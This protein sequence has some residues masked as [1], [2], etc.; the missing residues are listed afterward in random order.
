MRFFKA[1]IISP[2]LAVNIFL[3][4]LFIDT[5]SLLSFFNVRDQ[6]LHPDESIG[7]IMVP[8]ILFFKFLDCRRGNEMF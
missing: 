5:Y 3:S 8:T 2:L 7:K 1:V 6:V 4:T